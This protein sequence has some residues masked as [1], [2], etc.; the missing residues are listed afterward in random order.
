M[1]MPEKYISFRNK[2]AEVLDVAPETLDELRL[3][4]LKEYDSLGVIDL[5]LVIEDQ[6]AWEIP[7]E[8]LENA[9]LL[10][11]LYGYIETNNTHKP[12]D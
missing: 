1:S 4:D 7:L 8:V 9:G 11:D 3:S 5:G 2:V 12:G 6:F 10:I